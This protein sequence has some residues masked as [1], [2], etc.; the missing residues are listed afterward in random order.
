MVHLTAVGG[1]FHGRVLVARLGAEGILAE[2]RGAV[3]G[4]YPNVGSV[5]VWVEQ[6]QAEAARQLLLADAVDAAFDDN[7]ATGDFD[8]SGQAVIEG[9]VGEW[10]H[11]HY[12]GHHFDRAVV[13]MAWSLVVTLVTLTVVAGLGLF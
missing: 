1:S 13:V 2:V 11:G 5:D 6:D 12:K 4:P 9:S 10:D 8:P 3:D 7:F